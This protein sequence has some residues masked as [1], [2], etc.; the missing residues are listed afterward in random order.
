MVRKPNAIE[1]QTGLAKPDK[2]QKQIKALQK[3]C[4]ELEYSVT[5]IMTKLPVKANPIGFIIPT[6]N[7]KEE[8][9]S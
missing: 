5:Y 6:N 2:V 7:E 4:R 1:V 8:C 9:D 3:R